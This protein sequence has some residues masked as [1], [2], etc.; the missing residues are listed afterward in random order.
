MS[1]ER[2]LLLYIATGYGLGLFCAIAYFDQPPVLDE[3][4]TRRIVRRAR[5]L[6]VL[7]LVHPVI[8]V[9]AF[10][11]ARDAL[12]RSDAPA[13]ARVVV[14]TAAAATASLIASVA[15]MVLILVAA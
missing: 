11:L 10:G 2:G 8:A 14:V 1:P 7:G 12:W 5:V 3:R 6:A 15:I 4:W 9:T 13:P